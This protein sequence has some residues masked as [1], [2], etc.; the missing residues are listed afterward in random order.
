MN[1][2]LFIHEDAYE[3]GNVLESRISDRT[4]SALIEKFHTFNAL[5]T[6]LKRIT[7]YGD[8]DIF[9]LMAETRYRLAEFVSLIDFLAD[10][11][12]ILVIPDDS[13]G[14]L[15]AVHKL[16]PRYFTVLNE[17]YEDLGDV[18]NKMIQ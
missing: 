8:T 6:R 16:F 15:T 10:K 17:T 14:T 11:R 12:L 7:P 13:R 5:K 3:T 18:L 4:D 1:L 9:I 2:V